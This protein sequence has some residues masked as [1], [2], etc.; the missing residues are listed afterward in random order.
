MYAGAV[1]ILGYVVSAIP[2]M[3]VGAF[4]AY[5]LRNQGMD[6][7][8]KAVTVPLWITYYAVHLPWSFL[9]FRWIVLRILRQTSQEL[10]Q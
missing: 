4:I 6:S 9:C 8:V 2:A 3:I 10:A 5:P 1:L 7:I